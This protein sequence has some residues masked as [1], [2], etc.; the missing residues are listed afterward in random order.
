MHVTRYTACMH[1]TRTECAGY[2]VA[3]FAC[4]YKNELLTWKTES[5]SLLRNHHSAHY[6]TVEFTTTV[7]LE[8]LELFAGNLSS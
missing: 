2:C 4:S 8:F 1:V 3:M 7:L 6:S 5:D